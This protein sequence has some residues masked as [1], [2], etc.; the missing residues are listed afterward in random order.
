MAPDPE[1]KR[2]YKRDPY[3][4]YRG[5]DVLRFPVDPLPPDGLLAY[6]DLVAVVTI[7]DHDY[8]F[9]LPY[10]ENATGTPQGRWAALLDRQVYLI[11]FDAANGTVTVSSQ[12]GSRPTPP[13]RVA[14]WFEWYSLY[15]QSTPLP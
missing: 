10:L 9:A 6:K 15:P 12:D 5:S 1:T 4:S 7:G 2:L 3:H 14:Y 11:S 8:P 13:L